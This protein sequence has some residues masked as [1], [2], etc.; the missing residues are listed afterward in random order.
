MAARSR[1]PTDRLYRLASAEPTK[2]VNNWDDSEEEG[3]GR[4]V[5]GTHR[6]RRFST[7]KWNLP[8][9]PHDLGCCGGLRIAK[10]ERWLRHHHH[11]HQRQRHHY[12]HRLRV[13]AV[14][15][16]DRDDGEKVLVKEKEN[17]TH[18]FYKKYIYIRPVK[19]YFLVWVA[20]T[21]HCVRKVCYTIVQS[22]LQNVVSLH[23][24]LRPAMS[25]SHEDFKGD[26][27]VTTQLVLT[28]V[29]TWNMWG[30]IIKEEYTTKYILPNYIWY[31]L[32][33]LLNANLS[34]LLTK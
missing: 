9:L 5:G 4:N 34:N 3:R 11:H 6:S 21:T 30:H 26:N 14:R 20:I 28:V 12:H 1:V 17:A 8:R 16:F 25:C 23:F 22:S 10:A 15:G 18:K 33:D 13:D 31:I 24:L 19:K 29:I 32:L 2:S 27:V 7:K